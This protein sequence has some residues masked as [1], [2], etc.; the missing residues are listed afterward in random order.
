M[1]VSFV[2]IFVLVLFPVFFP[3][4]VLILAIL[5][6]EFTDNIVNVSKVIDKRLIRLAIPRRE[7]FWYP[8]REYKDVK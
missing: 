2:P 7:G 6:K 8:V 3:I 5:E 1:A 4:F